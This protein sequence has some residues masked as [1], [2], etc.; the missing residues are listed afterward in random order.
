MRAHLNRLMRTGF[1]AIAQVIAGAACAATYTVGP[2]GTYATIQAGINAAQAAG[3]GNEVH[4]EAGTYT[5]NLSLVHA[6]GNL[7]VLGGWNSNFTQRNLDPAATQ[8]SGGG[9][10][11]VLNAVV[12]A[13]ELTF[14]GVTFLG[15]ASNSAG[16]GARLQISSTGLV[17]IRNSHFILNTVQATAANN[18]LGGAFYAE[19]FN[20]AALIF[21]VHLRRVVKV[22]PFA[23][24][25]MRLQ[26]SS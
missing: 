5:E 20:T 22:V 13:G 8:I 3:G 16:A 2:D 4:V 11:Q 6:A 21:I 9:T 24:D 17:Q 15:G 10:A 14:S 7:D 26:W 19:L 1:A 25:R 12:S 23:S 18:G